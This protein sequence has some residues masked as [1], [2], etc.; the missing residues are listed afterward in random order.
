MT[1]GLARVR[2]KFSMSFVAVSVKVLGARYDMNG[3]DLDDVS[4]V[5]GLC[6]EQGWAL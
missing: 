6:R 2:V 5:Y 3:L 4:D 1:V